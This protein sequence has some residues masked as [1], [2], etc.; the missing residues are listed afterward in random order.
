M[1]EAENHFV[2]NV[3][4]RETA[5]GKSRSHFKGSSQIILGWVKIKRNVLFSKDLQMKRLNYDF[6]I[7]LRPI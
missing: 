5:S 7:N 6:N 4:C 3:Y 1:E 2:T